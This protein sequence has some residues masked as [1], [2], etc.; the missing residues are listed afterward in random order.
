MV[1]K[2]LLEKYPIR[3]K[4]NKECFNYG[5]KIHYTR[6]YHAQS[7]NTRKPKESL[8]KAKHVWWKKNQ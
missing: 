8:E 1:K 5:K 7:S 4:I 3:P 2:K 6:D